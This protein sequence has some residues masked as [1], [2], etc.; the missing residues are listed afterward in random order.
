M[1]SAG[2]NQA[3]CGKIPRD[4]LTSLL[5]PAGPLCFQLE[6]SLLQPHLLLFPCPSPC[7]WL[8]CLCGQSMNWVKEP[9]QKERGKNVI[10]YYTCLLFFT[11][12]KI[13]CCLPAP[14]VLIT[15]SKLFFFTNEHERKRL[16]SWSRNVY[17]KIKVYT[18]WWEM[19]LLVLLGWK[20]PLQIILPWKHLFHAGKWR[21]EA[22]GDGQ[23]SN[24]LIHPPLMLGWASEKDREPPDLQLW[25]PWPSR[26]DWA[27]PALVFPCCQH[28]G[29]P[30][31][32]T[33]SPPEGQGGRAA[34]QG[35]CC[36]E[37]PKGTQPKLWEGF[38]T[39]TVKSRQK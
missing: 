25:K 16:D 32:P 15:L 20:K 35:S 9:D 30:A 37:A 38:L 1:R 10:L 31:G 19:N 2:S 5:G 14:S 26:A 22:A 11:F 7:P 18:I 24:Q 4:Q 28:H 27:L 33:R 23:K 21:D 29:H 17:M 12:H 34:A 39:L 8:G 13:I 6:A 3:I 36:S